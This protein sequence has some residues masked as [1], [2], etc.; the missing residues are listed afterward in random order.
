MLQTPTI[1]T[2]SDRGAWECVAPPKM[3]NLFYLQHPDSSPLPLPNIVDEP[4]GLVGEYRIQFTLTYRLNLPDRSEPT[5]SVAGSTI[6]GLLVI[7]DAANDGVLVPTV[8]GGTIRELHGLTTAPFHRFGLP[9]SPWPLE[10]PDSFAVS[11]AKALDT[12]TISGI[13]SIQG[14]S[15]HLALS[16]P[17]GAHDGVALLPLYVGTNGITGR[18][19]RHGPLTDP[20]WLEGYFCAVKL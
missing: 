7:R 12:S 6:V 9:W 14:Q 4:Y 13:R 18:W 3:R 1:I 8:E 17:S 5:S 20:V 16:I 10:A 11:L 2:H 19:T 15:G